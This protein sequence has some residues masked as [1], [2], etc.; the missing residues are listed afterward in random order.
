MED[1]ATYNTSFT[2][3]VCRGDYDFVGRFVRVYDNCRCLG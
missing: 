1:V 3:F 2:D